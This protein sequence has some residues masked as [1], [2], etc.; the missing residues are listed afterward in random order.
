MRSLDLV[1]A[2]TFEIAGLDLSERLIEQAPAHPAHARRGTCHPSMI[3]PMPKST[4]MRLIE[5][6][7]LL[8]VTKQR[9]HQIASQPAF[10]TPVGEDHRG[11]LWDRREVTEW[12]KTWRAAK[13][14][15]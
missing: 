9:A 3:E 12:A 4:T 1:V 2:K 6:A 15:R 7:E 13:P 10:P 14:W 8:G 11:W 5:I